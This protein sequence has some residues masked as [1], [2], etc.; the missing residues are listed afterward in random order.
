[1]FM[2]QHAGMDKLFSSLPA[3]SLASRV[4]QGGVLCDA[5]ARVEARLGPSLA[6]LGGATAQLSGGGAW[7]LAAGA[8][9]PAARRLACA[10][11]SETRRGSLC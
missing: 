6:L 8:H 9:R 7:R 5:A 11:P 3:L 4:A 2:P 1:M 10:H